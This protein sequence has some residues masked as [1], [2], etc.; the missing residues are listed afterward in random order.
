MEIMRFY[1]RGWW[2][3]KTAFAAGVIACELV[4]LLFGLLSMVHITIERP[5][6]DSVSYAIPVHYSYP[7]PVEE[8]LSDEEESALASLDVVE[9]ERP[10]EP[11]RRKRSTARP[12][13]SAPAKPVLTVAE[14]AF[15]AYRIG[16]ISQYGTVARDAATSRV[17]ASY[18]LALALVNGGSEY[19]HKANNHFDERCTSRTCPDGHCLRSDT[20]EQHKWF[21]TRYKTAAASYAAKA[22]SVD[23]VNYQ[24][25]AIA[26]VVELYN[27]RRFDR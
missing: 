23:F 24:D 1:R 27:L 14:Q 26:R 25:P 16:Y 11:A 18:L 9:V 5:G 7:A 17:P 3:T 4:H 8:G 15:D 6:S 19:A 22:R 13:V 2:N 10:A 20:P 12:R 21:F